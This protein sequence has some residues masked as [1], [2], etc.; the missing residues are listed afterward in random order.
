MC[1]YIPLYRY[2]FSILTIK[3]LGIPDWKYFKTLQVYACAPVQC[4]YIHTYVQLVL[5]HPLNFYQNKTVTNLQLLCNANI[6]ES[7]HCKYDKLM[8][9]F[10]L[11]RTFLAMH[12]RSF[13]CHNACL[14]LTLG[15][16]RW[17]VSSWL[18]SKWTMPNYIVLYHIRPEILAMY[19]CLLFYSLFDYCFGLVQ[20]N[21]N[22]SCDTQQLL[23]CNN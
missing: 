11:F 17:L 16:T 23:L 18:N 2:I 15:S 21:F 20:F 10:I 19:V 7:V 9:Y 13:H 12:R 3:R 1:I 5:W 6:F 4:T 14:P 22:F 8:E